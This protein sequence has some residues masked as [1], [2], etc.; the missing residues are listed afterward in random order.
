MPFFPGLYPFIGAQH[1]EERNLC[2]ADRLKSRG[3]QGQ[4]AVATEGTSSLHFGAN[5]RVSL[6]TIV[7]L[8]EPEFMNAFNVMG[9]TKRPLQ[10]IPVRVLMSSKTTLLGAAR[11]AAPEF[12]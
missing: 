3:I 11:Y 10:A 1:R 2:I 6:K 4:L 8:K 12:K 5:N 9:R 7:K